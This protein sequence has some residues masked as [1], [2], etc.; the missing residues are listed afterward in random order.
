M[1][2]TAG[3]LWLSNVFRPVREVGEEQHE[4]NQQ[5]RVHALCTYQD[6]VQP[7]ADAWRVLVTKA[8]DI[9][10]E[11]AFSEECGREKVGQGQL[12]GSICEVS[13]RAVCW[14]GVG[15][16]SV[17]YASCCKLFISDVM[18]GLNLCIEKF[19]E[20]LGLHNTYTA[21]YVQVQLHTRKC[22]ICWK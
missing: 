17:L 16:N 20:Y 9:R 10:R 8:F 14:K 21:R 1:S 15:S 6:V 2:L 13:P 4:M 22:L 11:G 3:V 18:H 12:I 5:L 19:R 7:F